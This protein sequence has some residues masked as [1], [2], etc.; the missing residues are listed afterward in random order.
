MHKNMEAPLSDFKNTRFYLE[1]KNRTLRIKVKF[2]SFIIGKKRKVLKQLF[3]DLVIHTN[4]SS[5]STE[6]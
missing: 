2:V 1:H 4:V 6:F 5:T 3:L